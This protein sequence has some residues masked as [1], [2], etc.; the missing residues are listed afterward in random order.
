MSIQI[1]E[2][3]ELW[4]KAFNQQPIKSMVATID[5]NC[6]IFGSGQPKPLMPSHL[7]D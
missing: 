6:W 5:S 1:T 2:L 3:Y 4:M 7:D